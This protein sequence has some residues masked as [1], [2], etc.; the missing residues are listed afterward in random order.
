MFFDFDFK[1]FWRNWCSITWLAKFYKCRSYLGIISMNHLYIK[2]IQSLRRNFLPVF[3]FWLSS[4][5]GLNNWLI[6]RSSSCRRAWPVILSSIPIHWALRIAKS[7]ISTTTY[8]I[9]VSPSDFCW[10][11]GSFWRDFSPI[12]YI[13]EVNAPII[14]FTMEFE[15]KFT[16]YISSSVGFISDPAN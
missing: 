12:F 3:F 1:D 13:C 14:C 7:I 11:P 15:W 16:L 8:M 4:G 2:R 5:S 10:T 6:T 9:S